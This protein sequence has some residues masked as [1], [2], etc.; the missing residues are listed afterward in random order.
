[1][2]I[3][4]PNK[5][6]QFR[7]IPNL[8]RNREIGQTTTS[9]NIQTTL[10]LVKVMY[11]KKVEVI[12]NLPFEVSSFIH[13]EISRLIN[14]IDLKSSKEVYFEID[15]SFRADNIKLIDSEP[16]YKDGDDTQKIYDLYENGEFVEEI[17]E[18]IIKK[19]KKQ[20]ERLKKFERIIN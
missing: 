14:I 16:L 8:M 18:D 3:L 17:T 11:N 13:S 4:Q 20:L 19:E 7:F 12:V 9:L 2:I 1:M 10:S 6:Y 5:T 15:S